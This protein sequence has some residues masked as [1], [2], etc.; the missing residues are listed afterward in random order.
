M[1]QMTKAF[2]IELL[3]E[4]TQDL[5]SAIVQG[6]TLQRMFTEDIWID[7]DINEFIQCD[8]AVIKFPGLYRA[9]S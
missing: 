8:Q 1:R 4:L 5:K 6:W 7:V 9:V 2:R 3:Q